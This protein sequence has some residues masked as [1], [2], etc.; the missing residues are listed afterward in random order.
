MWTVDTWQAKNQSQSRSASAVKTFITCKDTLETN[1][2]IVYLPFLFVNIWIL[3]FFTCKHNSKT[4]SNEIIWSFSFQIPARF[5]D[6]EVRPSDVVREWSFVLWQPRPR[7]RPAEEDAQ[8]GGRAH[9]ATTRWTDSWGRTFQLFCR[10]GINFVSV[11]F[12]NF[13]KLI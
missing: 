4:D 3:G 13:C 12:N 1:I 6:F 7:V 8:V 2:S 9:H 11:L 5:G 10:N